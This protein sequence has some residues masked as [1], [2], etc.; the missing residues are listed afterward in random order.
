MK[1]NREQHATKINEIIMNKPKTCQITIN[2][3]LILG[4]QT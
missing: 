2:Y 1:P 3:V 4:Y